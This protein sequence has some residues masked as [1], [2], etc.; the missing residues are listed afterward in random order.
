MLK[1]VQIALAL[2]YTHSKV[3]S[4]VLSPHCLH[5]VFIQ[6]IDIVYNTYGHVAFNSTVQ[7]HTHTLWA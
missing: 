7:T 5:H 1:F 2:H 4:R 6:H 3:N